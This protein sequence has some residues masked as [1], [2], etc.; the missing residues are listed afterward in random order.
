MLGDEALEQVVALGRVEVDDLDAA[1]AEES[2][3]PT[4]VRFSPIT[5][6]GM[7][8]SRIAP[9]HMSHGDS[10]VAIVARR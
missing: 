7:P 5:R 1:G 4:N 8:Y 9:V 6:R 2:S 3:P 10:V